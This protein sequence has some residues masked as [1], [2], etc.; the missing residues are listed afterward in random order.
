MISILVLVSGYFQSGVERRVLAEN[1][2]V[3][4]TIAFERRLSHLNDVFTIDGYRM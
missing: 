4:K 2:E 3:G 1:Y